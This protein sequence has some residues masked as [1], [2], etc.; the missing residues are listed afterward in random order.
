MTT[1]NEAGDT[2]VDAVQPETPEAPPQEAADVAAPSGETT[3]PSEKP[4][5]MLDAASAALK[6]MNASDTDKDEKNEA[7]DTEGDAGDAET[8]DDQKEPA[9][10]TSA[11]KIEDHFSEDEIKALNARTQ[12]SFS[13][14][15]RSRAEARDQLSAA[16][17]QLSDFQPKAQQFDKIT[18][19]MREAELSADEVSTGFEL[20][21]LIKHDP[22]QALE[23]LRPY[24][25]QLSTL[26]GDGDLS[27]ELRKQVDE[28]YLSEEYARQIQS[29][30][31]REV[32]AREAAERQAKRIAESQGATRQEAVVKTRQDAWTGWVATQRASDPVFSKIESLVT[33]R[34]RNK[35]QA[36]GIPDDVN[37]LSAIFDAARAEIVKEVS[38]FA[39]SSPKAPV[40][41][42]RSQTSK[43]SSTGDTEPKSYLDA[44][45]AAL[46]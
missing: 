11:D 45:R 37:G 46:R 22:V 34:V 33:D 26:T 18:D 25:D 13:R 8:A 30:K 12:K 9:D 23:K 21:R 5:S 6:Q 42:S 20:M 43:T 16:Q 31:S 4:Q 17:A 41:P 44:A 24:V 2:P 7:S 40:T 1:K 10:D 14:I 38:A 29:A 19:F 36:T 32:L 28:G 35:L 3:E 15:L 27:A 39:P